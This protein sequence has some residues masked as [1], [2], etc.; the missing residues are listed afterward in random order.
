MERAPSYSVRI[1]RDQF[2]FSCAHMTV[3]GESRKV[4]LHGHNF[5]LALEVELRS[6]DFE[7][8]LDFGLLKAEMG[9]LCKEWKERTLLAGENPHFNVVS[10]S[11]LE[12]EFTLC[13]QRYVLPKE[14]ALVLPIDNVTVEGLAS[15]AAKELR[16]RLSK[17]LE[18]VALSMQVIIEES[19]GQG[20]RVR[21]P[22]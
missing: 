15:F 17:I 19:P 14:D 22:L 4:R 16:S 10:E 12:L 13:G 6:I 8:L 9:K 11:G 1:A 7:S 20:A 2:K 18:P 5:T 3:F 21:L